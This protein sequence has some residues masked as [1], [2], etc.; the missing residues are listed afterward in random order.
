M[1]SEINGVTMGSGIKWPNNSRIAVALTFEFDAE[2]LRISQSE[3]LGK[4]ATVEEKEKGWY[5]REFGV[6]SVCLI[7]KT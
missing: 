5:T 1:T 4:T 2:I 6:A 7:L 3:L